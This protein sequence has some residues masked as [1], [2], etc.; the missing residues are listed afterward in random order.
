VVFEDSDH[1]GRADKRT[2]FW[3]QGKQVTSVEV[4]R[5]GVWLLAAPEMLFIPDAD[6]DL[7]P[8]GEPVVLLDGWDN[9]GVRHNIVNGLRW[10]PDGWLYGRHGILATSLVG[11][12]GT[13]AESR[14]QINCG[15]W[16]YHPETRR[17][18]VVCRGTT[19]PWGMDWTE[20]G[21]LLFI[22]T[23]IGHL[24]HAI[25]NSHLERM[26]GNDFDPHLYSLIPQVA[27]HIHW[28]EAEAWS[29]IRNGVSNET[30][31]AG[32]GHAHSGM[33]ICQGLGWPESYS[34]AV[35]AI[36]LH[37]RR[38]NR[39][40]LERQGIGFTAHHGADT[41]QS[42]DPWFR[43]VE[44]IA[45]PD[46]QIWIADWSD[47]GE[48]HENDGVSR[49]SG[50]ILQWHHDS[51]RELSRPEW[52]TSLDGFVDLVIEGR[53]YWSRQA[54]VSLAHQAAT[55]N[56]DERL[57][58]YGRAVARVD[59]SSR[60]RSEGDV[61]GVRAM[62]AAHA[63]QSVEAE[64]L[65][66]WMHSADPSIRRWAV[67][68]AAD[69]SI[70]DPLL[71]DSLVELASSESDGLVVA[72]LASA[73]PRLADPDRLRV[74]AKLAV[75]PHLAGDPRLAQMIWYGINHAVVTE[76]DAA[77]A[78]AAATESSNL[79]RWVVRRLASEL[80]G[81][82]TL[83]DQLLDWATPTSEQAVDLLIGMR[84]GTRGLSRMPAPPGWSKWVADFEPTTDEARLALAELQALFG[85]GRSE[86]LLKQLAL[87][88]AI[89]VSVRAQAME[90]LGQT[91]STEA[92][93]FLVTRIVDRDTGA[94]AVEALR[95]ADRED[96]P[97]A[98][99]T[100]WSSMRPEARV[101]ALATLT[102]R[103]S[104]AQ[105][106]LDAVRDGQ[107][108]ADEV[109]PYEWR[110]IA[111]LGSE[112]LEQQVAELWPRAQLVFDDRLA[113]SRLADRLTEDLLSTGDLARGGEVFRRVCA[114]CHR[115]GGFGER[116][117]P[118]LT[119]S[120]RDNLNY[121]I[122][123][124]GAPSNEVATSFRTSL[125][126]LTDGQVIVGV[127]VKQL[128]D[129]IEVQTKDALR[130][131]DARDIEIVQESGRS[132]MPDGLADSLN[133]QDLADLVKYLREAGR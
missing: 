24:W 35:L 40:Y 10:G 111:A 126:E 74:A 67:R 121:L 50:R 109:G 30:N 6:E 9:G 36:N 39:D 23:V 33:L 85:D 70:D 116:I 14:E 104:S 82:P 80:S 119:G 45:G 7:V 3:D 77:L 57:A 26:Y 27:D 88:G 58:A 17:F 29:D 129:R 86:E 83:A 71:I 22:N 89:D 132:L 19:N 48:C 113:R 31:E 95:F 68:L 51:S 127:I 101:A 4:G 66:R 16:R 49:S 79:R 110:Q 37:G 97:Q 8:D 105:A 60:S 32:G 18:E 122:E 114:N 131:I 92:I 20:D 100:R 47:T 123:N 43:G 81:Q 21:E 128:P 69:S 52:P 84:D 55:A 130:G 78:L 87:D 72:Y 44:M 118:D 13:P 117:G 115:L 124:I 75:C 73:L 107:V 25:P 76:V 64:T 65:A 94:A 96:V 34:N 53:S 91:R 103:A 2:V 38:I 15:I 120:Q 102:A 28:N 93:D 106:L 112:S 12:P 11:V 63:I 59:S 42:S 54:L 46:G 41:F 133:D 99:I 108:S 62:W 125:I 5:G 98:I 1:D 61:S 56:E 90:S